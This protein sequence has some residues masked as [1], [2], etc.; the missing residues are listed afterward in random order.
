[1][2]LVMARALEALTLPE[3]LHKIHALPSLPAV[4]LEL[5]TSLDQENVNLDT[6]ARKISLDQALAAKTLRLAN[7]SFY[8]MQ[9]QV[10]TIGEAIA[11]LGIQTVRNLATTAAL[12]GSFPGD[13]STAFDFITFWRHAIG[14]ALCARSLAA[15]LG[16][17]PEQAYI[18][19][20]LHDIGR[21]VLVTQFASHYAAMAGPDDVNT[22]DITQ[23]ERAVL[24][25]DHAMVGEALARHWKFPDL[26]QQAIAQHHSPETPSTHDIPPLARVIHVAN[27]LAHALDMPTEQD[28]ALPHL[29]QFEEVN[30]EHLGLNEAMLL[31]VFQEAQS[32]LEGACSVLAQ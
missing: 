16:L 26:I 30:C 12:I 8:G 32:Q 31:K 18:A 15:Q 10:T 1:M 6:L 2:A 24:G 20:L 19:G 28:S 21:L 4:V 29:P 3:V 25:L 5:L 22:A 9:R 17:N 23:A 14:T 11:V 27:A 13:T 7:S